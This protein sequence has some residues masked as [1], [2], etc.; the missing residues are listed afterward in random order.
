MVVAS[1]M[2]DGRGGSL[3]LATRGTS[4]HRS[5]AEGTLAC[6]LHMPATATE[7]PPPPYRPSCL[8][9]DGRL[10]MAIDLN[11]RSLL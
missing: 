1:I 6:E 9:L 10:T 11:R 7:P 4:R 2:A 3:Q 5:V 8:G